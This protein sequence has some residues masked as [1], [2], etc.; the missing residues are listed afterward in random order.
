VISC[1]CGSQR[2]SKCQQQL[3]EL[4]K[5]RQSRNTSLDAPT[6]SALDDSLTANHEVAI[7]TTSQQSSRAACDGQTLGRNSNPF[8][9]STNAQKSMPSRAGPVGGGSGGMLALNTHQQSDMSRR[10]E[11]GPSEEPNQELA[12]YEFHTR[13]GSSLNHRQRLTLVTSYDDSDRD[14]PARR[15]KPLLLRSKSDYAVRHDEPDEEEDFPE[16]G[17]RHGFEDH[18][19]SED[20][21][22]NLIHVSRNMRTATWLA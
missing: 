10:A 9:T 6:A 18:Y 3:P 7:R 17:A 4:N 14:Q 8:T 12:D 2:I 21:I 5:L 15:P 11:A 22:S 20:I 13:L 19:Q 1:S 16:F